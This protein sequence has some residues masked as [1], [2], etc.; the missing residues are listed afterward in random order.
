[1]EA[2]FGSVPGV[3]AT[4]VGYAGGQV[5]NPSYE[6]VCSGQTGHTEV[7][8]VSYDPGKVS[9][10]TLLR[11]FWE[12]HDPTAGG[13]RQYRSV[14]FYHTPAQ[15]KAALESKQRLAQSGRY[16]RPVV[17]EMLPAPAF[18]QAEEYHQHYYKKQGLSSACS[19][20]GSAANSCAVPSGKPAS[21]SKAGRGS[22]ATPR[23][24]L[25]FS[26]EKGRLVES[27]TIAKTE[28]EW[29][30]ILKKEQYEV[31]RR[32]GTEQPFANAYWDN[33]APG[34]YRCVACGNDLFT[35][36]TKFNS[37]TGWPSFWA[38]VAKENLLTRTDKSHGLT[39]TEVLCRRCGAHLGHVFSDGPAPSGLRYCINSASL[40]FA[41]G[42]EVK[43]N[44]AGGK[45]ATK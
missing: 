41:A 5:A 29:R 26:V 35:S 3:T 36:E 17:T 25:L 1:V 22:P 18:Y 14:I 10:D 27:K 40:A 44:G 11:V 31:T 2:A 34:I 28:A 38:P 33:H 45:R 42:D 20:P 23:P 19:R 12:S 39:R 8:E 15:R 43:T 7:V 30:R 21:G 37:G 6:A 32:G 4:R 24:I 13:K 9:Y 16:S